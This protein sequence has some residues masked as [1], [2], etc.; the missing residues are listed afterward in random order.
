MSGIDFFEKTGN[1][2]GQK[3]EKYQ[4]MLLNESRKLFPGSRDFG[5]DQNAAANP[6]ECLP[7]PKTA[8]KNQKIARTPENLENW[9]FPANFELFFSITTVFFDFDL[10]I[11]I[12][13][14]VFLE[15][16]DIDNF[17]FF[18]SIFHF[19]IFIN[20]ITRWHN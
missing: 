12:L 9:D 19:S 2:K 7:D 11:S 16:P 6:M 15:L 5:V 10:A 1:Y 18:F 20:F 8:I 13:L 17:N 3:S 4:T 14:R